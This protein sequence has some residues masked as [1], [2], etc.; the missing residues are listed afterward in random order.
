MQN[1]SI[2][3]ICA[4]LIK[5]SCLNAFLLKGSF[6]KI[7]FNDLV[8]L[9]FI[10]AA[11]LLVKVTISSLSIS[12]GFS[13]SVIFLITLSTRTAVLPEPAAALTRIFLPLALIASF[14][15]V[16]HS[17]IVFKL[18]VQALN[19]LLIFQICSDFIINRFSIGANITIVTIIAGV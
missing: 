14:C 17:G 8:I 10:S 18:L 15:C 7:S 16:V 19:N 13:L 12:T 1:E 2:V 3:Q 4:L 9:D 5:L 6:L 11:A